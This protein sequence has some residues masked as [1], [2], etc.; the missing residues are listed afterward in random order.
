M[1]ARSL[2]SVDIIPFYTQIPNLNKMKIGCKTQ[3]WVRKSLK[4]WSASLWRWTSLTCTLHVMCNNSQIAIQRV[5]LVKSTTLNMK[6]S[7][8]RWP[9]KYCGLHHVIILD[10]DGGPFRA[11]QSCHPN[12]SRSEQ[13]G[14]RPLHLWK[15]KDGKSRSVDPSKFLDLRTKTSSCSAHLVAMATPATARLHPHAPPYTPRLAASP[16]LRWSHIIS[17]TAIMVTFPRVQLPSYCCSRRLV[18]NAVSAS[19]PQAAADSARFSLEHPTR[20][21]LL[22]VWRES[23]L[24]LVV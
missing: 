24:Y 6:N 17:R 12:C 19:H 10:G 16:G 18:V 20:I 14:D 8:S 1:G 5:K 7:V 2:E 23:L 15:G 4:E 3:K 9:R 13:D 21:S 22:V 11:E